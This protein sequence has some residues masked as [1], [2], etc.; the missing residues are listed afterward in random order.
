MI[1]QLAVLLYVS[2]TVCILGMMSE[3]LRDPTFGEVIGLVLA[4]AVIALVPTLIII[5]A[6][7]LAFLIA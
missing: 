5:G 6:C 4:S 1:A 3:W 7:Y 2:L